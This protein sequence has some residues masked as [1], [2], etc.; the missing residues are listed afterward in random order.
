MGRE[1]DRGIK[2]LLVKNAP[3]CAEA[4]AGRECGLRNK[5]RRKK[6]NGGHA[7]DVRP[8]GRQEN[9]DPGGNPHC[10]QK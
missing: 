9:Y 2:N 6:Y 1:G 4:S 7:Y 10:R 8:Y 5:V 3:A